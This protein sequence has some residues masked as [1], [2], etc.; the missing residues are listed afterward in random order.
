MNEIIINA[1]KKYANKTPIDSLYSVNE[2]DRQI[3]NNKI[4]SRERLT[5]IISC[6][7]FKIFEIITSN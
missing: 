4:E 2:I 1:K 5:F 6:D 3:K 7:D